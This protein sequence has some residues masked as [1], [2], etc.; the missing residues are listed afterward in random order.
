MAKYSIVAKSDIVDTQGNIT[1]SI[2]LT[3][4]EL[5]NEHQVFYYNPF[6]DSMEHGY[7]AKDL[8]DAVINY[9]NRLYQQYH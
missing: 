7:Y 2:V 5:Y 8:A 4:H 6:T 9:N 1:V 3:K